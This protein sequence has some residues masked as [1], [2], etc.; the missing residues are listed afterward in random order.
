[1]R[2]NSWH[3]WI[4]DVLGCLVTGSVRSPWSQQKLDIM[5]ADSEILHCQGIGTIMLVIDNVNSMKADVLVLD[6]PRL[7]FDMLTGMDI[8]KMLGGVNH[9]GEGN[10]SRMELCACAVIRIEELDFNAKFDEQ[11]KVCG[12]RCGS[13]H[14]PPNELTGYLNIQCLLK[15]SENNNISCRCGWIMD[16]FF[17]IPMRNS[18]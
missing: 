5:T 15:S 4:P 6:S 11:T 2:R 13:G 9:H 17:P 8:T 7:G 1:M 10:F 18:T 12:Q 14:H 3:W 16:G